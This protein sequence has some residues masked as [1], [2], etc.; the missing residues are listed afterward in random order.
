MKKT[1]AL[2]MISA[3]LLT[4]CTNGNVSDTGDVPKES[5]NTETTSTSTNATTDSTSA[6]TST[7]TAKTTAISPQTT[8]TTETETTKTTQTTVIVRNSETIPYN[9][10][11]TVSSGTVTET[12]KVNVNTQES[13]SLITDSGRTAEKSNNEGDILVIDPSK[14][15]SEDVTSENTEEQEFRIVTE[16]PI[17][18]PFIPAG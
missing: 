10:R 15:E 18:L 17:E 16:A 11:N 4:G 14:S 13:A 9:E 1:F 5:I 6:T 2:L 7:S 8:T 3:F 12:Q